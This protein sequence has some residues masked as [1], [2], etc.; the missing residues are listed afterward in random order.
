MKYTAVLLL[1]T[2][3]VFAVDFE[4]FARM[5]A[6]SDSINYG[7]G[8]HNWGLGGFRVTGSNWNILLNADKVMSGEGAVV[9]RYYRNH[10]EAS[11]EGRVSFGGFTVNPEIQLAKDIDSAY[12]VL[13]LSIGEGYRNSA[14]RPGLSLSYSLPGVFE[15]NGTGRYWK[16]DIYALDSDVENTEWTEMSYGGDVLW[17]TPVGGYL[18]VGGISHQTKLD[19]FEYDRNWSRIDISAGVRPLHFPTMTFVTAEAEYS[20]YT[21]E[22]YAGTGLPD[23]F[24]A[25]LRA[26]QDVARNVMFNITFSQAADFYDDE[27]RF[28]PFQ[29]AIRGQYK[30]AG[31]GSIPSSILVGGQLTESSITTK[32]GE[33]EARISL[34]GG[35]S[36]LV[37]GKLWYG[38][39]S[40]AV[41]PGGY[42]TR[43]IYGGGL[44]FRMNNG[45]NTFVIYEQEAST[46][47]SNESWGKIRGGLGF[48]PVQF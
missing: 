30:F 2:A 37:T 45:L 5:Q 44:E 43:E 1:V 23:R 10:L 38:P 27:T 6:V 9:P 34:V 26:V 4:G 13:P 20:L 47:A 15:V 16:R 18:A 21:G 31:W 35:L 24:T 14:L 22:D 8:V 28:G 25:R 36:A 42:R 46:L 3:C 40:V 12:V 11:L 39:S 33:V 41:V 19:G 29:S 32:L 7:E 17:H 48:Y